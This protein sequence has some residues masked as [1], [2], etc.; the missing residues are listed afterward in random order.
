[1]RETRGLRR[2]TMSKQLGSTRA[3]QFI[4]YHSS[5]LIAIQIPNL[6]CLAVLAVQLLFFSSILRASAVNY[7]CPSWR[8][9]A[10]WRLI[11]NLGNQ[12][13]RL[14]G[15]AFPAADEAEFLRGL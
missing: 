12:R 5:F 1:M 14:R 7:S 8:S 10:S 6:P 15:D 4:V 2:E 9:C 13:D 3:L 11:L